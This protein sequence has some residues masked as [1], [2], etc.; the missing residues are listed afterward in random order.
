VGNDTILGDY[1]M[2]GPEVII[3]SGSHNHLSTKIP[4]TQQGAPSRRP[5]IIGNDVWIGT[6]AIILPGVK[7]GNHVIV[8]AGSVVTKD[9]SDWEIVAGNPA[10]FIRSRNG[11]GIKT[12]DES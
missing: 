11:S 1:V 8:G 7:I 4:M 6:R 3:I 12:A 5:V 9:V 2:M 10:I